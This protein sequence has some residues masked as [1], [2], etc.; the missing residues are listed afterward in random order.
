MAGAESAEILERPLCGGG[1]A[2]PPASIGGGGVPDAR[3]RARA[4]RPRWVAASGALPS[5]GRGRSELGGGRPS[6]LLLGLVRAFV[7]R[8]MEQ[9]A[10]PDGQL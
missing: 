10:E 9:E 5:G 4:Q 2:Q 8:E 1:R 3:A 7:Y 6:L